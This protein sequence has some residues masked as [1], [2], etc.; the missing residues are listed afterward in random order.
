MWTDAGR[1]ERP[2]PDEMAAADRQR[3]DDDEAAHEAAY[4]EELRRCLLARGAHPAMVEELDRDGLL[5]AL[6][7]PAFAPGPPPAVGD[8]MSAAFAALVAEWGG[9]Q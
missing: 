1:F 4:D 9:V 3:L 2:Y 7:D 8:E 5:A 6:D